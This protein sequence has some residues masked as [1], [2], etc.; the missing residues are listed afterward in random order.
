MD[1]HERIETSERPLVSVAHQD[2]ELGYAGLIQRLG[3]KTHFLFMTNGDG[4]A[5]GVGADPIEYAEMRKAE[6]VAAVGSL[7]IPEDQ[8]RC[9]DFSEI[10]IYG[11]M[12]RLVEEPSRAKEVI[13][14]FEGV[15]KALSRAV[16]DMAPDLV[17][18]PAYQ[19]GHPEHDLTHLFTAL[20]LDDLARKSGSRPPL[21]HFPEYELTILVPMRFRPWFPGNR[22]TLRLTEEELERKLAMASHY[23]SQEGLFRK[24]ER[25]ATALTLPLTLLGRGGGSRSYFATEVISQVPDGFDYTRAPYALD[26]LNY[27]FEDFEG[28]PISFRRSVL[29]IVSHFL[30]EA[31]A[32]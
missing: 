3:P 5:P 12:A 7:G 13:R 15:R 32:A 11:H 18:T 20:A 23:P 22:I 25:I 19:G 28:T 24:F 9:L 8:V 29:P 31:S 30:A 21:F 4:L 6:A 1:L 27:M 26:P 10:A 16:L 17:F 2:D 14:Y